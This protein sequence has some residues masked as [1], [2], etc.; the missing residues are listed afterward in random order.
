MWGKM[1]VSHVP[2]PELR[3]LLIC[4]AALFSDSE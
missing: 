1:E 3:A 4:E 2:M